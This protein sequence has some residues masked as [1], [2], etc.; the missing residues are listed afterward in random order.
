MSVQ[1]TNVSAVSKRIKYMPPPSKEFTIKKV[2]YPLGKGLI[3]PGMPVI[4]TIHFLATSLS[5]FDDELVIIS[6]VAAF[7][8]KL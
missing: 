1:I 5:D 7:S 2:K 3:A 8:V 4:F 6:D